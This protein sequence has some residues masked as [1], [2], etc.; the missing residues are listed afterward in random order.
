MKLLL[1][2]AVTLVSQALA[3]PII[4]IQINAGGTGEMEGMMGNNG[5]QMGREWKIILI[6][7]I[8]FK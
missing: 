2:L 8:I 5:H 6:F 3:S 7:F 1:V 4:N